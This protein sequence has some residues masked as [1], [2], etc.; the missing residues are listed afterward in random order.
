LVSGQWISVDFDI[1]GMARKSSLG[2]IVLDADL[3]TA[4]HG[5]NFYVDNIYLRK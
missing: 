1:S 3:G 4:L 2:Q 5:A